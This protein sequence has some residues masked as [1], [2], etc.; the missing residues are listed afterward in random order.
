[1]FVQATEQR[2]WQ[3]VEQTERPRCIHAPINGQDTNMGKPA[4][5]PL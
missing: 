3:T 1:M 5:L 4:M 2:K